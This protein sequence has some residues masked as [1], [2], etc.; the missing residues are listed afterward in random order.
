MFERNKDK[1]SQQPIQ[2]PEQSVSG[3]HPVSIPVNRESNTLRRTAVIGSTIKI[4]GEVTGDED[5]EIEGSIEGSIDLAAHQVT[6]G[7]TGKVKA[8]IKAKTVIVN[9]HVIGDITGGEKVIISKS[10]NINGNII[11]P[12]MTLEDGAI[13]KG[14]ID[15]DPNETSGNQETSG[16]QKNKS[17]GSGKPELTRTGGEVTNL[18]IKNG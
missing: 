3:E 14:S 4:K 7:E 18:D 16:Q 13:F 6:V 17:K 9:G 15:M 12:R 5:L 11:T 1:Q 2:A 10:G 8:D